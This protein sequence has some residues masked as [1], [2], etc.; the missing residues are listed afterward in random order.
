MDRLGLF[1]VAKLFVLPR[2]PPQ[3]KGAANAEGLWRTRC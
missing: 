1:E 3:I 2:S